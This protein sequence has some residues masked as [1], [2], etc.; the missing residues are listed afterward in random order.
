MG[1][2]GVYVTDVSP[3]S[4]PNM[5]C[6]SPPLPP[7]GYHDVMVVQLLTNGWSI[8]RWPC[9]SPEMGP[10][11]PSFRGFCRPPTLPLVRERFE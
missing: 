5:R 3:V 11:I 7:A 10:D 9:T 1:S 8:V 4:N 2:G 6:H